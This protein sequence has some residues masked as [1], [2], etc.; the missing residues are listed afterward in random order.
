[1]LLQAADE[2]VALLAQSHPTLVLVLVREQHVGVA[3][4]RLMCMWQPLPVKWPNGFGMKVAIRP[5]S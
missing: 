3:I 2:V 5:R 4:Q 1:V